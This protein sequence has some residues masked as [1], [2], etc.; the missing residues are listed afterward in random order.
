MTGVCATGVDD[1]MGAVT[2]EGVVS[3]E[4][5]RGV[6]RTSRTGNWKGKRRPC[7]VGCPVVC[8]GR[9]SRARGAKRE[10]K[11][12][13]RATSLA[14]TSCPPIHRNVVWASGLAANCSQEE[15]RVKIVEGIKLT[16]V[17]DYLCANTSFRSQG[18]HTRICA[19]Q[20]GRA[21]DERDESEC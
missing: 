18:S 3:E 20:C 12:E 2:R 1:E 13:G 8:Q 17:G 6:R 14:R 4:T 19:R 21:S 9:G 11:R 5:R 16:A 15:G 7:A 10:K